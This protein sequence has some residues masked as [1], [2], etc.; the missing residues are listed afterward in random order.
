[1]KMENGFSIIETLIIMAVISMITV[2]LVP[3]L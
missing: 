3:V 2:V 1:M